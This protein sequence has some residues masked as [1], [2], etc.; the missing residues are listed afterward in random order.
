MRCTSSSRSGVIK[1]INGERRNEDWGL[2]GL[3]LH[4]ENGALAD[5]LCYQAES[6]SLPALHV[7][8]FLDFKAILPEDIKILKCD[9]FIGRCELYWLWSG[10]RTAFQ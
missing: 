8:A 1:I 5:R 7:L 6:F 2:T 10:S 9:Y 3:T 4:V